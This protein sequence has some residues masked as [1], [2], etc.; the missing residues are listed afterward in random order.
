MILLHDRLKRLNQI[1]YPRHLFYGPN[2]LLLGVNNA[3]NLHCKMCDVG[4]GH[5]ESN[6]SHNLAGNKPLNMPLELFKKICDEIGHFYPKTKIDYS[7][8]EPLIYPHL[9]TSLD[10]ARQKGITTSLVTNGLK[11]KDLAADLSV[12]GLKSLNVS[13]DGP[14]ETHNMIRGNPHSFELAFEGIKRVLDLSQSDIKILVC[15]TI[16]EWNYDKMIEFVNI[17]KSL[18]LKGIG[19][20]HPNF[21][22]SAMALDHNKLWGKAYPVTDSS[23][24]EMN[25]DNI[26]LPVL[27]EQIKEIRKIV[28]PFPVSFYP[29]LNDLNTLS[30]YYKNHV[31][32]IGNHCRDIFR[33]IMVKSNGDVIPA[34]GKCYNVVAGNLYQNSLKEIWNSETLAQLRSDL[35]KSGGLMPGCTRCCGSFQ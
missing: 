10:Y 29:N 11:L 13:L 21:V 33:N 31:Q 22:T 5:T 16:T 12:S 3:C 1:I 23:L 15:H 17:F 30:V 6:Y 26:K 18:H 9:L 8:A 28:L 27:L 7:Y 35:I 4:N 24:S 34:I 25:L 32:A 19:F 2:W 14:P 20:I